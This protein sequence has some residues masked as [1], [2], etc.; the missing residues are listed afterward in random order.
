[1]KKLI[2]KDLK[3]IRSLTEDEFYRLSE[4]E[5]IYCTEQLQMFIKYIEYCKQGKRKEL[6]FEVVI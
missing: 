5:Q 1:M 6:D 2:I 3:G 4:E